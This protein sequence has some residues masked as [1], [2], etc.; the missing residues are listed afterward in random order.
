MR[1]SG[2]TMLVVALFAAAVGVLPGTRLWPSS[3]RKR[4]V[5]VVDGQRP[6]ALRLSGQ[7]KW[8]DCRPRAKDIGCEGYRPDQE[9]VA[10]V[11]AI[12]RDARADSQSTN[13]VSRWSVAVVDLLYGSDG[14]AARSERTD[15]LESAVA[16]DS[17]N[18]ELRNDLAVAFL[19]RGDAFAAFMALDEIE[20]AY[21]I[22]STSPVIAFNRAMVLDRLHLSTQARAA[23]AVYLRDHA[24]P[25]WSAEATRWLHDV[26]T[27][28]RPRL[29]DGRSSQ[30]AEEVDRDPQHARDYV[31]DSLLRV[32]AKSTTQEEH[33]AADSACATMKAIGRRLETRSGDRSVASLA[34]VCQSRQRAMA[35]AT[36]MFLEGMDGFRLGQFARARSALV[37][38]SAELKRGATVALA[39]WAD[40]TRGFIEMYAGQYP[41]ADEVFLGVQREASRRGDSALVA[42]ALWGLGLSAARNGAEAVD[43]YLRAADLYQRLGESANRAAMLS[44]ASDVLLLLGRDEVA[45]NGKVETLSLLDQRL[46]R[47]VRPGPFSSLGSE[48]GDLGMSYAA[49]AVLREALPAAESWDR[50]TDRFDALIQLANAESAAQRE[51][52]SRVHLLEARR[53]L[54]KITDTLLL[55]RMEMA[56]SLATAA[57]DSARAP[58]SA[59]KRL[60]EVDDYYRKTNL[61]YNRGLPLARRG[62]LRQR[63]GDLAGARRDL[64]EAADAIEQQSV[65]PGDAIASRDRAAAQREVYERLLALDVER[66]DATT[67]FLIAERARGHRSSDVP[68]VPRGHVSL[69]YFVLP[70]KL[71]VWV[72]TETG[73]RMSSV[74]IHAAKLREDV[75]RAERLIRRGDENA[76]W[77]Q[78]SHALFDLLIS[79]ARAELQRSTTLTVV[80]DGPLS[81]LPFAAL[82]DSTGRYL[83][84]QV[85][86]T[87]ASRVHAPVTGDSSW[88]R[89]VVVGHPTFDHEAFPELGALP[90][91]EREVRAVREAYA[92]PTI[93]V[94]SAATKAAVMR[95]MTRAHLFHFAG[96]ARLVDRAP[97]LSHLVLARGAT[98]GVADN[99]LSASDISRMDLRQM[100]L[101]ILSSC[102]TTQ[103]RSRRDTGQSG[104]SEAFL[105]AGARSVISSRWE[106]DDDGTAS[107]MEALHAELARGHSPAVA[108]QRAQ[109]AVRTLGSSRLALRV[110]AAFFYEE[111]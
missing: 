79:P 23:W 56:V 5:G 97:M 30:L 89:P 48:L 108:L 21:A 71:L 67:A 101:V 106:V 91:A 63:L 18:A 93:I 54:A 22:D 44:Q 78:T 25:G 31:L 2:R 41:V 102:G 43:F 50:P 103:A 45:I 105:S 28:L 29:F 73:L 37:Q 15:W 39:G 35:R 33:A 74:P 36:T 64:E 32:W 20:R 42:R 100:G 26:E 40:V 70:D 99:V 12:G 83:A 7:A 76:E 27:R 6:F 55:Q 16:L 69:S 75:S 86:L 68:S 14:A 10:N 61:K 110:W 3:V 60:T 82:E 4:T 77:H 90:G 1:P 80:A 17:N 13:A 111:R 109:G 19:A 98:R 59:I 46:D 51:Q 34:L 84:E 92:A 95:A 52:A 88:T 49:I 53:A 107:L 8:F 11:L 85:V 94:D 24:E 62:R 65:N 87:Y 81:R 57:L 47:R 72:L 9:R 66:G 104:L 38:A 58:D 96:H